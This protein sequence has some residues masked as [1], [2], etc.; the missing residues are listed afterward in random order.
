MTLNFK[1]PLRVAFLSVIVYNWIV[2]NTF[3]D[4][5]PLRIYN[6]NTAEQRQ[7]EDKTFGFLVETLH[8][9]VFNQLSGRKNHV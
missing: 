4:G 5:T 7:K 8:R 3:S 9:T 2:Y 1:R 6:V